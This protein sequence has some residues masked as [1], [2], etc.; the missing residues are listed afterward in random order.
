MWY[1]P[2]NRPVPQPMPRPPSHA[3]GWWRRLAAGGGQRQWLASSGQIPCSSQGLLRGRRAA[4]LSAQPPS[5]S[6]PPG[7]RRWLAGDPLWLTARRLAVAG[8]QSAVSD[9]S[10]RAPPPWWH[11]MTPSSHIVR[12]GQTLGQTTIDKFV[13][14]T[15]FCMSKLTRAYTVAQSAWAFS[16][17]PCWALPLGVFVG[18]F[19]WALS[20]G[21]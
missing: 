14:V 13:C 11:A 3:S 2:L 5:C 21:P 15:W 10:W 6:R 8:G 20:S 17:G 19:L 16:L 12:C 9:D 4:R 7:N 1:G 18:P